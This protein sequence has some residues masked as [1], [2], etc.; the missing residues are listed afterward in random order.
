MI[1]FYPFKKRHL[2]HV[3]EE[4]KGLYNNMIWRLC[5]LSKAF[6]VKFIIYLLTLLL[7]IYKLDTAT[8]N[9]ALFWITD[10]SQMR[11]LDPEDI[12]DPEG[13]NSQKILTQF[14]LN[15]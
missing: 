14:R 5:L 13:R 10:Y 6:H 3:I 7:S 9:G 8:R 2:Q 4:G 15:L 11:P 1:D 12:R